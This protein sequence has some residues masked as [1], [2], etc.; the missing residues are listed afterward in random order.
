M[1]WVLDTDVVSESISRRPNIQVIAWAQQHPID[2]MSISLVTLAEIRDG[3]HSAPE[4]RKHELTRWLDSQVMATFHDRVL[5][6]T[7]EVLIDWIGLTRKLAAERMR[8]RAADL[9]IAA[10]ARVHRLVLVT[11][12][13]RHFANTGVVV[14]D[15]WTDKTHHMEAP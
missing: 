13:V 8:R 1:K 7:A 6:L 11:R 3:I 2:D 10:T 15:P 4:L 9:L 5:P 12:N 14:Y